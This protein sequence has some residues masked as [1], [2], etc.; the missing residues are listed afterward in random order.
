MFLD[1][2]FL[3]NEEIQLILERTAEGDPEK[4]PGAGLSLFNCRL[5]GHED[6]RVRSSNRA[7]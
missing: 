1:T 7:Q 2:T 4:K 3:K 5:R 6:G